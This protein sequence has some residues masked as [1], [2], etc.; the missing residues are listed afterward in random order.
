MVEAACNSSNDIT[1]YLDQAATVVRELPPH[2][3]VGGGEGRSPDVRHAGVVVSPHLG[4]GA[5]VR[6]VLGSEQVSPGYQC[7]CYR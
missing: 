7:R 2:P 4:P 3:R 1:L 5:G 6:G